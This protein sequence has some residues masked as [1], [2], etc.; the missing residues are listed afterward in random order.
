MAADLDRLHAPAVREEL[1]IRLTRAAAAWE[2]ERPALGWWMKAAAAIAIAG[3]S[4]LAGT[5]FPSLVR[6]DAPGPVRPAQGQPESA[7]LDAESQVRAFSERTGGYL[8]R[9]R[10]VLLE[11]ANAETASQSGMLQEI[12][13]KLLR[14]SREA[15]QVADQMA[16]PRFE[17]IVARLEG[18]L[19]EASRLSD[20]G[21]AP[22]VQRIRGR[23]NDSGVLE[24]LELLI[25]VPA[26]VTERRS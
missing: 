19:R 26:R 24:E 9:S 16:D 18:I 15:H 3:A 10:L 25:P 1:G 21:D 5:R 12:T 8:N 7:P 6:R 22:A 13:R 2:P 17:E 20:W 23:L 14:E 11:I 4:F